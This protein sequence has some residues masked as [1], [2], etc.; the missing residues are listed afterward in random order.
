[1]IKTPIIFMNYTI[2]SG[3]ILYFTMHYIHVVK[4]QKWTADQGANIS[5]PQAKH[6]HLQHLENNN[7]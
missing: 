2:K 1:M 6:Y 3:Q 4:N 7:E 5:R